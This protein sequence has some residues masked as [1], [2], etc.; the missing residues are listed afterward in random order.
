MLILLHLGAA[1]ALQSSDVCTY[2][3]DDLAGT[4]GNGRNIA[5]ALN[6]LATLVVCMSPTQRQRF[7]AALHLAIA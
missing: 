3:D 7:S 5:A 6:V 4:Q 1:A 2:A